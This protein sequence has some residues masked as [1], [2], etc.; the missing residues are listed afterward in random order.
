MTG[1]KKILH[2]TD[3]SDNSSHAL[4]Y[5]CG[6]AK[7]FGAQLHLIHVIA[8]PALLVV[9]P[10]GGYLPE[11][12]YQEIKER[13]DEELLKLPD[14]KMAEGLVIVRQSIE[15]TAF[16]E[17]GRYAKENDIDMIV[18]GTHGYT[19]ITHMVMGSVAEKVVRKAPCPV[20]TVHPE[21]HEFILP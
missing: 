20:L 2:P 7:H 1:L 8:D 6:F 21:D 14:E 17:I 19:G 5:A 4:I 11:G 16:M 10:A 13:S 9:P 12:Y 18:L 3:F 15:G